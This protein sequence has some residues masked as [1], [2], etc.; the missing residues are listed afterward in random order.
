M[1]LRDWLGAFAFVEIALILVAIK[2]G[3][4]WHRAEP[5]R[6]FGSAIR[7]EWRRILLGAFLSWLTVS[8][9]AAFVIAELWVEG[10]IGR[11]MADSL[12]I[13]LPLAAVTLGGM[14]GYRTADR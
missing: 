12:T 9:V 13:A 6:R 4:R 1:G 8:V 14:V 3:W 7:R 11:D 10:V 2:T 5:V